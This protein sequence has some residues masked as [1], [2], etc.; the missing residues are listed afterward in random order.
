MPAISIS[1]DEQILF[2]YKFDPGIFVYDLGSG[3]LRHVTKGMSPCWSPDRNRIAF[4]YFQPLLMGDDVASLNSLEYV[5]HEFGTDPS[6]SGD[7]LKIAYT[8]RGYRYRDGGLPL[9]ETREKI[10]VYSLAS[11]EHEVIGNGKCATWSPDGKRLAYSVDDDLSVVDFQTREARLYTT[12]MFQSVTG[13]I[14]RELEVLFLRD[15][16]W[17]PT[18]DQFLYISWE[19]RLIILDIDQMVLQQCKGFRPLTAGWL[20]SGKEIAFAGHLAEQNSNR[21]QT[22]LYIY[23]MEKDTVQRIM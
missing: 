15:L 10:K 20:P 16:A 14:K 13:V 12:R 19:H 17:S 18:G 21:E 23:S 9:P 11:K 6:W 1:Q 4:Q 8:Y 5:D 7:G 2:S 3:D 22:G